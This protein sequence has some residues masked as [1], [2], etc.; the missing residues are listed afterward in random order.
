M[1]Y[2]EPNQVPSHLR[3][4][5]QGKQFK[6]KVCTEMTIPADAG[7]WSD[8]SRDVYTAVSFDTGKS[9]R[10]PGQNEAPWGNRQD[11]VVTLEPGFA[12]V[13]HTIFRGKDF[14]L[15]F[16]LHPDNAAKL[17]PA[18]AAEIS[19]LERFVLNAA[20]SYKSSYGGK[21]RYQMAADN[22]RWSKKPVPTRQDY[23]SAKQSLISKGLLNKVGAITV[24]GR[25]L[26]RA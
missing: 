15:T 10:F 17:L 26:V 20:A 21:D 24:S 7:L 1:T 3:G 14:G 6:A 18:P 25:N 9:V 2:L 13:Q 23:D 19:E 22:A 5:Y 11:R 8:G 4:A 16:Y 12:V